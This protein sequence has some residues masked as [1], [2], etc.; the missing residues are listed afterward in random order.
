ML[1]GWVLGAA[2]G[3]V[4]GRLRTRTLRVRPAPGAG[5]RGDRG[6]GLCVPWIGRKDVG[7]LSADP[8]ERG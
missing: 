3:R 1:T 4:W 2:L 6:L 5:R 8:R 7:A